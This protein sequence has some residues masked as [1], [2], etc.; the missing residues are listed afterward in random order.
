[1][2]SKEKDYAVDA[3]ELALNN[4]CPSGP[5][6]SGSGEQDNDFRDLHSP[7]ERGEA[8]DDVPWEKRYEKLWVEVEKREVKSTFKNVAGELKEKFG[9]LLRSRRP[10]EDVTEKEQAMAENTSA[11]EESSDEEEGEVIVRPTARARS[12]VLVTIPEQRESGLEDSVTESTDKS[13]YE[14]R[15][16]VCEHPASETSMCREP[17]LLTDEECRSPSPRLTTAQ[18]DR[19]MDHVTTAFTNDC[20]VPVPD[21][22]KLGPFQ[23][24]HL[25]L[26]LKDNTAN[27][28]EADKNRASSEEVPEELTKSRPPSLSRCSTSVPGVSDEELE[29]DM[30][31]FKLE[32][33]MLKVVF[34]D[35]EKEKAQ[36]QKEVE[37]GRPSH[38]RLDRLF[39]F[40]SSMFFISFNQLFKKAKLTIIIFFVRCSF[41][42]SSYLFSLV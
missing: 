29:E 42:L 36:L 6:G 16:Q 24:P 11:E 17:D 31:R 5:V 41:S 35:L 18:R 39:F 28:D 30:E 38:S 19:N 9:E 23:K 14:D 4:P 21:K 10:A 22:A 2:P 3:C 32:V 12:T 1:M 8:G 13:V 7:E 20:T 15:M 27:L 26:T 25:D 40:I 33:G 34:L 37:D